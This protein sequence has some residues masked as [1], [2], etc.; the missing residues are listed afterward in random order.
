MKQYI[1]LLIMLLSPF[2]SYPFQE[3]SDRNGLS[4]EVVT[5]IEKRIEEGLTPSIALAII[6]STGIQYFNFGLTAAKGKKVNENTIYEIGSIT[7]AFTGILLAKQVVDGELNLT[8]KINDF[9]PNSIKVPTKGRKEITFGNLSDHTSGLPRM[10]E[11]FKPANP[12]N[13]YA[14]YTVEQMYDYISNYKPVRAVGAAYEYS[15]LAQGLL[16]HLLALNQT[17]NYED[18]MIRTI[19][20]PLGMTNTKIEFTKKM[21]ENLALGHAGGK[22]VENWDIPTLA[23]AGAI[24]SSTSDMSKFIAANLGYVKSPIAEAMELSHKVRHHKAG[25][26]SVGLGW[27]IKNGEL[28]DV[29]WHNGGTGGYRAFTGFV[30]ETGKGVVLLSNS[31]AAIDDIGFHLLDPGTEL[32]AF[33]SKKDAVEIPESTL[34]RYIGLYELQPNFTITITKEGNQL[35]GQATGQD[36]FKIYPENDTTF[37]LT[38]VEAKITFQL[39]ND[40]AESLTLFQGGQEIKGKKIE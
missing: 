17:S 11:N 8:D 21:K 27:H 23:G 12:Y 5:S 16:G 13:P 35:F 31:T 37:Y 33:P 32:I 38:V 4:T 18:L 40:T 34:E 6:D 25:E 3:K 24:R 28:G 22:Q 14:D 15:N 36:R 19:A 2:V 20:A 1:I 7:K 10:P 26:M 29:I 39:K 9:L 30:K